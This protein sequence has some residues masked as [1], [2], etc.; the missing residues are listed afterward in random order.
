M[1]D[2]IKEMDAKLAG[3]NTKLSQGILFSSSTRG[4]RSSIT[5]TTEKVDRKVRKGPASALPSFCPFCGE[6]YEIDE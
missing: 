2:C 6:K 4:M 1:C 3:Y 5:I